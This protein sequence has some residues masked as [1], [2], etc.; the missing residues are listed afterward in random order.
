MR[1]L[2]FVFVVLALA[3]YAFGQP[4]TLYQ[5]H[6][7]DSSTTLNWFNPWGTGTGLTVQFVPGNPSGDGWIGKV[8]NPTTDYGTSLAGSF[9][10]TDYEVQAWIYCTVSSSPGGAYQ[11]IC[12]RWDTTD[13]AGGNSFY[14]LRTDFDTDQRLQL[15]WY[16]GP[17]SGATLATWTGAQIPGG[18]PTTDSWHRMGL[19]C[20]GNQLWAWWDG[21]LLSGCPY[22]HTQQTHGFFGVYVFKLDGV[23]QT[24]CDDILVLDATTAQPL[25]I[26]MLPLSPPILIPANGGSFQF[27]ASVQRMQAPQDLFY[28]WARDRYP[29]GTYT[30]N[31]L[32]PVQINPPVGVTVTRQRTQVVPGSWPP[33]THYYIGYAHSSVSYPATDADSFSWMKSII[34]DGGITVW[35]TVNYGEPF[36]GEAVNS[37]PSTFSLLSAHPNPFNP[38]TSISYELRA[39]SY[40]SLKVYDASGRLAATLVNGWREMG[41][42]EVTFDGSKLAAGVYLVK[43]EASGSGTPTTTEVQKIVLLK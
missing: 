10:M 37:Q 21:T 43:L 15:R 7:T 35:E 5:E 27:D 14:Y 34:G 33:G 25:A 32:G 31:L 26:T 6:F 19:K 41:I 12:A 24:L 40:V 16:G 28:V 2:I 9:T 39:A 38:S 42:H 30:A 17:M 23:A 36:P 20:V 29:D 22:T 18:V 11:A 1:R 13:G 8:D 4:D 3:H